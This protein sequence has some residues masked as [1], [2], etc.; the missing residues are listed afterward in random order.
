[1][2]QRPVWLKKFR[3]SFLFLVA[4][5]AWC[6]KS[7]LAIAFPAGLPEASFALKPKTW[8]RDCANIKHYKLTAIVVHNETMRLSLY[9]N[10]NTNLHTLSRLSNKAAQDPFTPIRFV[11]AFAKD[12]LVVN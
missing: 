9:P 5:T 1:M 4:D 11:E 6:M 8:R 7:G 12:F 3:K 10:L 2:P